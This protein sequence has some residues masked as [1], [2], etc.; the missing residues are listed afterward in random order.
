MRIAWD[1][2]EA[3]GQK[4]GKGYYT[5]RLLEF[6]I[7]HDRDNEY[8]LYFN[9][10]KLPFALPSNFHHIRTPR[11]ALFNYVWQAIDLKRKKIDIL[12]SSTSYILATVASCKV[13]LIIYDFAVYHS[14]TRPA[15]KTRLIEKLTLKRALKKATRIAVISKN[16]KREMQKLFNI[17]DKKID[18]VYGG[19]DKGIEVSPEDIESSL[20]KL[21]IKKKFFLFVGTIEPRKNVKNLIKAYGMLPAKKRK[22]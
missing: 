9:D 17:S 21:K 15:L 11:F 18:I 22:D 4:A 14:F 7:K 12:F 8:F 2:K 6:F 1:I 16:T 13:V 3:A 20:A 10:E 5:Y 19:V